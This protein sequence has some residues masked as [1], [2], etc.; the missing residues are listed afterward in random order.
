MTTSTENDVMVIEQDEEGF[1]LYAC[2]TDWKGVE[3][4]QWLATFATLAE[5]RKAVAK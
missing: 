2:Y 5:A 4:K 1:H 3:Q